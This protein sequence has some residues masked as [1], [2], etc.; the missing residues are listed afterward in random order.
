MI[1]SNATSEIVED[2][3]DLWRGHEMGDFLD[4]DGYPEE[5]KVRAAAEDLAQ[6]KPQLAKPCGRC[7]G[8]E[9][10]V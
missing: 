10:T 5:A 4:E 2:P 3:D 6:S 9:R 8:S 7:R 1:V